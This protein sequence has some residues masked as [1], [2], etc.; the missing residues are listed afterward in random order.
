MTFLIHFSKITMPLTNVLSVVMV[1]GVVVG[2][3]GADECEG[4]LCG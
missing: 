2:L 4:E 3:I 1:L